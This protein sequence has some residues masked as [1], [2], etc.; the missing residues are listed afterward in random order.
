MRV[1]AE[2]LKDIVRRLA[3]EIEL[4]DKTIDERVDQERSRAAKK[5][6][7]RKTYKPKS[8]SAAK[9]E[10]EKLLLGDE[11]THNEHD[12]ELVER[13]YKAVQWLV[14]LYKRKERES[15]KKTAFQAVVDKVKS[16]ADDPAALA[17]SIAIAATGKSPQ[18]GEKWSRERRQAVA[19]ERPGGRTGHERGE[20]PPTD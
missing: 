6:L 7:V 9:R 11:E 20:L 3:E 5:R 14:D 13:E 17:Q 1:T 4:D 12:K 16:W 15:G 18:E 2:Q 8:E 10:K 19:R